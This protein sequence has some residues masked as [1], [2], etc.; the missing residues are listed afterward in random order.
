MSLKQ[1]SMPV[2]EYVNN[3]NELARFGLDLVNTA[4]K[5]ALR[6]ARGLNQPLQGLKMIHIPMQDTSER[7][8]DMAF[9]YED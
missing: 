8:V 5:K 2:K 7:L 6:F 9:M 4:H 1:G 3:F